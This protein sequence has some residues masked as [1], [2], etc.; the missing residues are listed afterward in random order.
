LTKKWKLPLTTIKPLGVIIRRKLSMQ[1]T[2]R[3]LTN[4]KEIWL[5]LLYKE[6]EKATRM[7]EEG[8]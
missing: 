7:R 5:L 3:R 2:M 6:K 1:S 8:N 4:L